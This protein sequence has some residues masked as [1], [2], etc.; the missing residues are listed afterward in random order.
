MLPLYAVWRVL[1]PS[2]E[3]TFNKWQSIVPLGRPAQQTRSNVSC[4]MTTTELVFST[5][6][7]SKLILFC[8][9]PLQER[10]LDI[11]SSKYTIFL[12]KFYVIREASSAN[13]I[14]SNIP[15]HALRLT[16]LMTTTT[17]SSWGQ[18]LQRLLL[19]WQKCWDMLKSVHLWGVTTKWHLLFQAWSKTVL[20]YFCVINVTCIWTFNKEQ[21]F[22][23][24]WEW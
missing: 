14:L 19:E 4:K 23:L 6:I 9:H 15:D 20:S 8:L 7:G 21:Q 12:C 10:Y 13:H 11:V 22:W 24:Y 2:K 17:S 16:R 5:F 1:L 3:R 18:I